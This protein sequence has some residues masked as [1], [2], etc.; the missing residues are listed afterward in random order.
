M[1]PRRKKHL[2]I[3]EA[4]LPLVSNG[5]DEDGYDLNDEQQISCHV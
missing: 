4:L 1:W 2:T 5:E 3:T